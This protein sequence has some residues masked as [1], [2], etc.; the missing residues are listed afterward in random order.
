MK[1][2]FL[3]AVGGP[4]VILTTYDSAENPELLERI[5]SKGIDKF[6]I[7]EIPIEL[8]KS[9]YGGHFDVVCQNLRETDDLRVLDYSGERAFKNF[10]FK[11]LGNPIFYEP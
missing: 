1:A 11:E 9:R 8:A 3:F 5:R 4:I 6:V 10:S 2:Y 7:C